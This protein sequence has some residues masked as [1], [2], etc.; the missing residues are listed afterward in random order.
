MSELTQC[1][2]CSM[3][4]LE[5]NLEPGYK[6]TLMES[7][8]EESM[9]LGGFEVY[10]HPKTVELSNPVTEEEHELYWVSWLMALPAHCCC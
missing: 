3:R 9:G 4:N 7:T 2:Y 1:N 5:R 6:I 8:E 10:V